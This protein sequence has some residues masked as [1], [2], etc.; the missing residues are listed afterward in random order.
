MTT[1]LLGDSLTAWH[2]W[3][4]LLGKHLNHGIPGDTTEGLLLRLP[5]SLSAAPERVV[6][7]I[8]TNDLLQGI[9]LQTVKDH[10]SQILNELLEV[11]RL[12]VCAV[13]PVIDEPRTREVNENIIA[14]NHWVREQLWK[15][16]FVYVDL[17]HATV[18][19]NSALKPEYTTD[20][21]H[22]SSAGYAVWEEVLK[23]AL[24]EE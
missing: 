16:G 24:E 11:E 5:R 8:G 15:Y 2:D 22:L 18:G 23:E 4:E 9:P 19:K 7:T 1:L 17:Y 21:V 12:F 3:H 13:P 20:G 14:L 10:Y 6:L